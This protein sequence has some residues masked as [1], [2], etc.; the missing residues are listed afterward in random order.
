MD[1]TEDGAIPDPR[2]FLVDAEIEVRSAAKRELD[3]RVV[4]WGVSID[5][6]QGRE[7]FARGAFEGTDPDGV[8]LMGVEHEAHFG[9]G[10]DGRPVL[11]RHVT[12]KAI[13]LD[14]RE[15][16]QHATFRVARTQA[17]D[18]ILALAADKIIKGVSVEFTEIPNGTEVSSVNGRRTRVHNRARLA[19]VSP[20]Y[21]PAYAD[22]A[23][24][25]V[26]SKDE[27][28]EAGEAPMPEQEALGG[29][30]PQ[31]VD[32]TPVTSSITQ[33]RTSFDDKFAAL[34][35][36]MRS[37]FTIPAPDV[38][39][40]TVARGEWMSVVLKAM[41]GERVPDAQ[42]RV[43]ADI[44][45][46]D[47]LGVVP[48]AYLTE[49]IGVIDPSR[50]FLAST[51]RMDLPSAGMSI[52]VPKIVTRPTAGVQAVFGDESLS[53][54]SD[55]TS[56]LTSITNVS[57]D[58]VTIA[59]GADLSLQLI[60]RSSPSYLGLFLELL[61]EAY[62]NNAES[63][64]LTTLL[65][66]VG[67]PAGVNDG[68]NLDPESLILG[69]A[70]ASGAAV[71]KPINT[72]WLSSTAVGAFIDAK[73]ST[74]NA[75]LYSTIQAGFTAGGGT[76][77]TISGLRPIWVPALDGTGT[78]VLVGPSSGFG[79]TE[80]GTYTLQVDVPS[81]AG[82]DVALVG[83]LWFAPMYPTAFTAYGLAS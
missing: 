10:Q 41:S 14:D 47:N 7:M 4:P 62:A 81:K 36:R 74:T 80:D 9:L 72:M 6:L 82:R 48:D 83:I 37:N 54:K 30:E 20:T 38:D 55:I 71:R 46:A 49:L 67:A 15:D 22:A 17:G 78:D 73:A 70:W 40:Q 21:R 39:P 66:T 50:P 1:R 53:E 5:T 65:S 76:G 59:G 28:P 77:G 25:A 45:T 61:A 19:G 29:A 42:M 69:P 79:W 34:E 63:E 58:A 2:T 18:E 68:G 31:P 52:V 35:E 26:R 8:M 51:R 43:M 56:T 33:M 64:A 60:K 23:I 57:Y 16:G 75:P 27:T 24:L 44:I 32:L 13:A 3:V 11:T 12:G